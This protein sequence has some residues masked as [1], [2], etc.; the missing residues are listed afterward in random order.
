MTQQFYQEV[1]IWGRLSHPNILPFLGV[2]ARTFPLAAVS[3]WMQYGN[4]REYLSHF[5][6]AS[7][8][9]LVRVSLPE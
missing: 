2:D 4:L 7:R 3:T 9:G 5:P 8:L 1:L 6:N